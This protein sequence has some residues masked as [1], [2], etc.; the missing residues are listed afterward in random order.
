MRV[1]GGGRQTD[2]RNMKQVR[3]ANETSDAIAINRRMRAVV[4]ILRGRQMPNQERILTEQ[5][6]L[7]RL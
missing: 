7:C 1:G 5:S 4:A 2:E 6:I 3:G